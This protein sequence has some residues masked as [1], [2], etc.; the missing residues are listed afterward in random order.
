M[1]PCIFLLTA[2]AALS[3][4][5]CGGGSTNSTTTTPP[6]TQPTVPP[7]IHLAV[8]Q[9]T[10]VNGAN[11]W[12]QQG[13]YGTLGVAASG[14]APGG[15]ENAFNWI[16]ASGNLWLFGGS[17]YD[18]TGTRGNLN[19]LWKYSA[20]DWTW[21]GGSNLANQP[22]IYGI[23]GTAAPS[24]IPGA[25]SSGVTWVDASGNL[26]LF[27]GGTFNDLWKY[28]A[29]EWTWVGGANVASQPGTYG[30]LG[31]ASRSNTPGAR[32]YAVSWTDASGNFWLFGG[33]TEANGDLNDLWKYS[34][35]EWTW[36]NGSNVFNEQPTYGIQGTAAP[37]NN[38]GARDSAISWTDASGNFWLFGGTNYF[39]N[40]IIVVGGGFLNDL[41]KYSSGDWTWMG[42]AAYQGTY[43]TLGVAAPANGPGA[44]VD[45]A[46]WTDAS[47]NLWLFGG[48]GDTPGAGGN[49]NDLWKYSAGEWTWVN[50]SN[51]VNEDGTYGIQ[52]TAA[53][54]NVPG[55]RN[56]AVTWI[57]A[58]GNLW[59][60][61]GNGF[62]GEGIGNGYLND[63]WEYEP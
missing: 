16:D 41:W 28:S 43:G 24:N 48:Y 18:S 20:G 55:G 17:G 51:E 7:A 32:L 54:G 53:S 50:G 11:T 3:F 62:P 2:M 30:T 52:G 45:A 22:G 57:D 61:G 56:G 12:E 27:G 26:W 40:G 13:T 47:G 10:W 39:D 35:G 29:G 21:M 15:R 1:K 19:D 14:D 5:A 37:S 44:R 23:Q 36:M 49:L 58:S 34:A 25:R 6:T 33:W 4:S 42:S 9:W 59:L 38:P 60:F 31:V 8:N 46:G 63:L